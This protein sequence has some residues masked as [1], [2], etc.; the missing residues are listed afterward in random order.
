M[1]A[2]ATLFFHG[3]PGSPADARLLGGR[4][5]VVAPD[6]LAM[7]PTEGVASVMAPI[8]DEPAHV[9]GFSIGAMAALTAAARHPDK[10]ERVTLISPAAPLSLGDFLPHMQG[11]PVFQAARAP[12]LL[13]V[14][15]MG[16]GLF[17]AIAP[18]VMLRLLFAGATGAERALLQDPA[19]VGQVHNGLRHSLRHRRTRYQAWLRAYVA[20]WS[21]LLR[22]VTCAVDLW[23][24]DAD[25]WAP[26]AMSEALSR[27]VSGPARLH[28]VAGGGHYSTLVAYGEGFE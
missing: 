22:D 23:H 11:R 4:A 18:D 25:T 21:A 20:D 14:L 5:R 8:L 1:M 7:D 24:G 27:A 19:F 3:L 16:Q 10:I 2:P 15:S 17:S 12:A 9:I 13:S 28:R 26:L 6:L